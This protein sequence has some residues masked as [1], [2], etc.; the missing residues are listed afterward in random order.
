[1]V[2]N[3][4]HRADAHTPLFANY[5]QGKNIQVAITLK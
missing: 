5:I 3:F 4:I 2:I 1:M